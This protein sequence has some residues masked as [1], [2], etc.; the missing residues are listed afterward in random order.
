MEKNNDTKLIP[1]PFV[2]NSLESYLFRIT[3][4]SKVIYLIIIGF[5]VLSLASLP[6]IYVD[7]SVKARGYFESLLEKQVI[8]TPSQGKI[9]FTA[10][11]EGKKVTKGD[12]LLLIDF[13]PIKA[14]MHSLTNQM[15]ENNSSI[16]DLELLIKASEGDIYK[17][18]KKLITAKYKADFSNYEKQLNIQSFKTKKVKTEFERYKILYDQKTI[19]SVEYENSLYAYTLEKENLIQFQLQQKSIWQADLTQRKENAN[20]LQFEYKKCLD[21]VERRVITAPLSGEIIKSVDI[22][23]G[24]IVTI[25]QEVATISPDGELIA[26]CIVSPKDIGL[27]HENQDIRIQVDAY[28]YNQWGILPGK[29]NRISDDIIVEN[30]STAYFMVECKPRQEYLSLKNGFRGYIRKGMTFNAV[31][32]IIR[33]SLFNLLFDKADKWFNPYLDT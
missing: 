32:I 14:Q 22:Q 28:N 33:R 4:R 12:T 2:Q 8:Y 29:I 5:V 10:I 16:I 25:N 11:S 20:M 13:E 1:F 7:V 24:S 23:Q 26:M 19:S 15:T 9:I 31:I 6:F 18:K 27:L 21:E 17:Y 3:V 30:S